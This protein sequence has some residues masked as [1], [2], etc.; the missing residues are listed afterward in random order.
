MWD[1]KQANTPYYD[2]A[3]GFC[4]SVVFKK[5]IQIFASSVA[6]SNHIKHSSVDVSYLFN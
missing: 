1:L 6:V 3:S 2:E 4:P 5:R